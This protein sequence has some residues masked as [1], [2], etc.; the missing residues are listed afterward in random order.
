MK[1]PNTQN[2]EPNAKAQEEKTMPPSQWYDEE[3]EHPT[4]IGWYFLTLLIAILLM[5]A[6][7]CF[8]PL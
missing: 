2:L 7:L 8:K 3:T 6:L 4:H 5:T 1:N